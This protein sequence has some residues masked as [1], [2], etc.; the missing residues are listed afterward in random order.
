MCG[1]GGRCVCV[2][3]RGCGGVVCVWVGGWVGG[4]VVGGGGGFVDWGMDAIVKP[5]KTTSVVDDIFRVLCDEPNN[6]RIYAPEYALV[7]CI[8]CAHEECMCVLFKTIS[9]MNAIDNQQL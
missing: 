7:T 5:I 1:G 3:V 8:C 2:R 4:W 9:G 6:V